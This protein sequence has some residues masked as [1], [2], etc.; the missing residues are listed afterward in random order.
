GEAFFAAAQKV[1]RLQPDMQRNVA[2]LEDGADLDGKRLAA[3]VALVSAEPSALAFQ[4]SALVD[5]AAMRANAP[6]RPNHA[7]NIGVGGLFVLEAGLIENRAGHGL[8]PY[9]SYY[10]A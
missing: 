2:L 10:N 3:G 6:V 9:R 4:R 1:H 5:N 7:F 8:S